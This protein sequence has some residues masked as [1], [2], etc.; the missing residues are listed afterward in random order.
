M[1]RFQ[2]IDNAL[3]N[4]L[5]PDILIIEDESSRHS[6]PVGAESHFKIVIVSTAFDQLT[7]V[8]RHRLVNSI[9]N[10]EFT[11]GLHALSLLLYTPNEWQKNGG[12]ILQSP[13][14]QNAQKK[15]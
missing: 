9:L 4:A 6:V 8:A 10:P 13:P 5:K 7:R 11:L 3:S 12:A 15:V 2:R 14:C 1:L